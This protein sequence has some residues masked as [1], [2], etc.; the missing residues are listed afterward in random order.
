MRNLV[1]GLMALYSAIM[2]TDGIEA[3]SI[4]PKEGKM[5]IIVQSNK[6]ILQERIVDV[7][8]QSGASYEFVPDNNFTSRTLYIVIEPSITQ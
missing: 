3:V 8:S 5:W 7:L 1:T 6:R 4:S 2:D